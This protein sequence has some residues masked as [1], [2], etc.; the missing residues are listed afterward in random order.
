MKG[1]TLSLDLSFLTDK[2]TS[3]FEACL[4]NRLYNGRTGS[5]STICLCCLLHIMMSVYDIYENMMGCI[6]KLVFS[7][8]IIEDYQVAH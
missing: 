2:H 1:I 4:T 5:K 3:N 6:W 7:N 8:V